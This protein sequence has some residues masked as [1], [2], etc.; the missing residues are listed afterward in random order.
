[1]LATV[2]AGTVVAVPRS[3]GILH[4]RKVLRSSYQLVLD[5]VL[6]LLLDRV[7]GPILSTLARVESY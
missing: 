1:M 4:V 6:L 5:Y 7:V 3:Q 2:V